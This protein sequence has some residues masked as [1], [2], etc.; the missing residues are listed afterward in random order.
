MFII[1]ALIDVAFIAGDPSVSGPAV[2]VAVVLVGV[3]WLPVG[4]W[5]GDWWGLLSGVGLVGGGGKV[6]LMRVLKCGARRSS[7]V[8]LYRFVASRVVCVES[9][10]EKKWMVYTHCGFP[11]PVRSFSLRRMS[12][13]AHISAVGWSGGYLM[14]QLIWSSLKLS[15]IK[16][17]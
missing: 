16:P 9:W 1:E 6:C 17:P 15:L 13:L 10:C 4:W 5:V 3:A 11:Y 14:V 2:D 8:M 12:R 7:L